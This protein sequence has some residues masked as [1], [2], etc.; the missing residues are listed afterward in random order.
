MQKQR[1]TLSAISPPDI[2]DGS[3][4]DDADVGEI[5]EFLKIKRI[6]YLDSWQ[7]LE[8]RIE[9]TR[10]TT[11]KEQA[12]KVMVWRRSI[13]Q[14]EFSGIRSGDLINRIFS[15][16]N[17]ETGLTMV[18]SI[19]SKIADAVK[20][21][22]EKTLRALQ[23]SRASRYGPVATSLADD[24]PQIFECWPHVFYHDAL[25]PHVSRVKAAAEDVFSPQLDGKDRYQLEKV[26]QGELRA[27]E[28]A[29]L[30]VYPRPHRRYLSTVDLRRVLAAEDFLIEIERLVNTRAESNSNLIDELPSYFSLHPSDERNL[31][32]L[33]QYT[34]RYGLEVEPAIMGAE[35]FY[36]DIFFQA[37]ALAG[38][39]D[40]APSD[41]SITDS[42]INLDLDAA[43]MDASDFEK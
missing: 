31:L 39:L 41:D 11:L 1:A 33:I 8:Q 40:V 34:Q 19:P 6:R 26:F 21:L 25:Q 35:H 30:Q 22:D 12:S 28:R 42:M 17:A 43:V 2:S 27:I 38:A 7:E 10:Q 9:K 14:G 16:I 18:A 20:P 15:Q 5:E 23:F 36:N 3:N 29:L 13:K 4:R 37:L 24:M 32:T